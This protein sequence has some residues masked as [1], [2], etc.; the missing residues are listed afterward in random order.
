[1]SA[2]LVS[3]VP[4]GPGANVGASGTQDPKGGKKGA[5]AKLRDTVDNQKR[6]IANLK[7]GRA[8]KVTRTDRLQGAPPTGGAPPPAAAAL[9]PD[10]AGKVRGGVDDSPLGQCK[11]TMKNGQPCGNTDFCNRCHKHKAD[12]VAQASR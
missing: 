8:S 11:R 4:K 2:A 3:L 5:E 6:Q 12:W 1:M 9:R 7:G 10:Q